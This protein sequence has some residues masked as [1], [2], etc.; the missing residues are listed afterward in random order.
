[1]EGHLDKT[2]RHPIMKLLVDFDN[3]GYSKKDEWKDITDDV[4]EISG[5]K[6]KSG[7][8][9][10]SVTSDI[11]TFSVDNTTKKF[12]NDNN[13][14]PLYKKI[15]SNLKFRLLTGF[16]GETLVPYASGYIE[17]FTPAWRDKRISIKTTDYFK[18]FKEEK[19]P[20]TGFQDIS[21]DALV[22]ILCDTAG[23]P[24]FIVRNIP[25]TEFYYTYFKF[26]E[27]NC[28]EA[29]K[30][31]MAVAVGEA[32]FEQEQFYVKTKLALDY[33]LDT[34][35]DHDIT[36]D[37][38]FDFEENVDNG[39]II[40]SVE[41]KSEY[42]T[43]APIEVVFKTP[44]N[45]TKVENELITYDGSGSIY[46]DPNNLPIIH[47]EDVPFQLVNITQLKNI[48]TNGEDPL[49]GRVVIHPDSLKDAAAG[50]TL[51]FSYSYQQL[52]LLPGKTR[53]YV[54]SLEEEIDS[55][56][57]LDISIWD[58]TGTTKMQFSDTADTPNTVS[59]QGMT[60]D[61]KTNTVTLTIK[62]NYSQA[63]TISTL[64]FRGYPIK[65]ISPIDVFVK[66]LPSID[67]FGKKDVS[68]QN[69]YFNN[70]KLVQKVAQ[71][72]VDNNKQNRK[73]IEI[74]IPGYSEFSLDDVSKVTESGSGTN[75]KFTNER[76]DYS[77][78]TD[79]GWTVKANLVELDSAPWVYESFKGESWQRTNPGAPD[80][81]FL[82]NINANLIKNGGAELYTGF[83]DRDDIGAIE[84]KHIIPDYWQFTRTSGN[85]SSRIRD[86]GNL[87]IHG[88]HSFE[89]TT[90]N[91]GKGY[92]EQIIKGIK[93]ND[94]YSLSLEARLTSCSGK[95]S[96]FQYSG[97]T[98]LQTDSITITTDGPYDLTITSLASTDTIVIRIEKLAGTAGSESFVFDKVKFE[99]S[100]QATIY[101]EN[102][103]TTAVQVGQRYANSLVIGNNYGIEVLD[104][105][106]R[107]RV[108]LGQYAPGKF[109]LQI[110]GGAIEIVGGLPDSQIKSADSWN[111]GATPTTQIVLSNENQ[112]FPTDPSGKTKS[113]IVLSTDIDTYQGTTRIAG[114]IG[115]LA[116]KDSSGNVI[117][118]TGVTLSKVNPTSTTSGK[119]TMTIASGT[120]LAAEVGYI[121]I[122]VV[123]DGIG[124]T[125]KLTWSKVKDGYTPVKGTDYFDG[126]KGQDGTSNYLWV[127]YSQNANGNPMTTDPTNAKYIGT[128]VTTS[129]TAPVSYSSYS[130]SLVKGTDGL[131]G[132]PGA[133]GQT[134]YLHVKYSNDG[135]TTFTGNNGED[136]GTY[137]GTYVDFIQADS[138]SVSA[139]TWNKVKGDNG[140]VADIL[141]STQTFKSNDNGTTYTP[142]SITLTPSL[143]VVAFSKWQYSTNG[144]TSFT[145]VVSGQHGLTV[146]SNVLTI[147]N[148]SDLF[149]S[150][151]TTLTFKLVT[152]DASVYDTLTVVRLYDVDMKN[153]PTKD[154]LRFTAPLPTSISMD[155]NGITAKT[156]DP[157]KY[158]RLDYRGLYI[159]KGAIQIDGGLDPGQMNL[160]IGGRNFLY[161]STWNLGKTGWEATGSNYT[162][163]DPEADKP[164]SKILK[165]VSSST[166]SQDASVPFPIVAG[167]EYTIS[168][169]MKI[170]SLL[171]TSALLFTLRS[172]TDK[173]ITNSQAN[174]AWYKNLITF[175]DV[176]VAGQWVRYSFTFTPTAGSWLRVIPYN[177][178]N[179]G[180]GG[181]DAYFREI[182]VELGNK[183]SDWMPSPDDVNG[184]MNRVGTYID[185]N[186]IY[187]GKIDF[188]QGEGTS[189]KLGQGLTYGDG[190]LQVWADSNGDGIK[191]IIARVDWTGGYF[192]YMKADNIVGNVVNTLV[193]DNDLQFYIDCDNGNDSN[194]G[195][196]TSKRKRNL[197]AFI[198]SLPKDLNG[199]TVQINVIG[200]HNGD[201]KIKGFRNGYLIVTGP[202][203]TGY[204]TV[205]GVVRVTNC[206]CKI[207]IQSF[208][209][210]SGNPGDVPFYAV[211]NF[212]VW[213]YDCKV[214][215]N[216]NVSQAYWFDKTD[217]RLE[218]CHAYNIS[219]RG[220]YATNGCRGIVISCKGNPNVAILSEFSSVTGTGT[221]WG[222]SLVAW[223]GGSIGAPSGTSWQ[224]DVWSSVDYGEAAPPPAPP[225]TKQTWSGQPSTGD[226]WS[227]QGFWTNDEMKQGS[228]GYGDRTGLWY[229]DLS[230]LQGKTIDSATITVGS[231]SAG[232]SGN[233][234]IFIRTHRYTS[235]GARPGSTPAI[236]GNYVAATVVNGGTY[237]IDVTSLI[238]S[239]IAPNGSVDKSLGIYTTGTANYMGVTTRPTLNITYH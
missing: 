206:L 226:N 41:I 37:H 148:N 187:T 9:I 182:Q 52:A 18:L 228:W 44:E 29:L 40:N 218:S 59:M 151:V 152:N 138:N 139:Y 169:D 211:N 28:F 222:G 210:K 184:E 237:T 95:A 239:N 106:D 69:N 14:S 196:S 98:L 110:D 165:I 224:Q 214:Y 46:V 27:D 232:S 205:N 101:I 16:Q 55:L 212:F 30:S 177:A 208:V 238:Q 155:A 17:S 104:D 181:V 26:E 36:V 78:T 49:T 80:N 57:A 230:F 215:G 10:G 88:S 227:T 156:S 170:D 111:S 164:N 102:E 186:G 20:E 147:A 149:S 66:D 56:Q 160:N 7:D 195:L 5:S 117:S 180:T 231:I 178:S 129:G 134:S 25:K 8:D 236:S 32:Y 60:F 93:P 213:M 176:T 50:D 157:T 81:D 124:Y 158:A 135:G 193:T 115:T 175:K 136:V 142:S 162:I 39:N 3:L 45:I 96:V 31:L 154:D 21:W 73:R 172:F 63:V 179:S 161:N 118:Q 64:Q 6:E 107:S 71:Y 23:L 130:W 131:P 22:N 51:S 146:A 199:F 92:F 42:K 207:F 132:E 75:H 185:Q 221:R 33:Q 189:L 191:D 43:I 219:D 24:S 200:S 77:F 188:L 235:R 137:I 79:N 109:G 163:V 141:A 74:E 216:S 133:D 13:K 121:E 91:S 82:K 194:D 123:I 48:Q 128:A 62:N 198:D 100:E 89:V 119:I 105:L 143:Q 94:L 173:S 83:A 229:F 85:A 99:N 53:K 19:P 166:T 34:T 201:L 47:K 223:S 97:S 220:V 35:V 153:Y 150:T 144:G 87:V 70:V 61:S 86:G 108:K 171:N 54:C 65:V 192:P 234:T 4:I 204:A 217:F 15:K 197:Q 116:L 203:G 38:L 127:R 84:Q 11:A 183:A 12:N 68:I 76:I 225:Q 190:D 168:F 159:A 120:V 233:K 112:S 167:K 72:I 114:T 125:K 209:I 122:P 90:S 58:E 145:D 67:E 202:N 174:S 113:S 126:Q 2:V 103:E 140:R 1:M